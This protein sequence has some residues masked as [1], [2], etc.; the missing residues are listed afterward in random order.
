MNKRIDPHG[1]ELKVLYLS[2]EDAEAAKLL[3]KE[4]IPLVAT[5][6]RALMK[7]KEICEP[8]EG[9]DEHIEALDRSLP[10]NVT[11]EMGLALEHLADHLDRHAEVL[12]V[13]AELDVDVL[14][15]LHQRWPVEPRH[16]RARV[17]DVVAQQC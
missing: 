12:E 5:S 9:L 17:D 2:E 6:R 3:L 1:G 10:G 16:V 8:L 13:D 15:V 11:V 7:L 14:E 4:L